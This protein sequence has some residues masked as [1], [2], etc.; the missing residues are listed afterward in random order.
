MEKS[1]IKDVT[2]I[3]V[4]CVNYSLTIKS[5]RNCMDKCEF[6]RVVF[7]TDIDIKEEGIEVIKIDRINSKEEYSNFIIKYLYKY[8]ETS[9]CLIVQHDGTILNSKCWN[10]DFKDYDYIGAKWTYTDGRNVG[11]GGFSLRSWDLQ[12]ILGNDKNIIITSPEDECI[13]RLYRNYL[14]NEYQVK[15]APEEI[16]DKFSFELHAPTQKTFGHHNYFF[17]EFKEHIILKRTA[18][19]G[20]VL[21]L[22]P[23]I[24]YYCNKNYQVV[25]DTLPEFM[26][27]FSSYKYLIKH[28]SQMD[29]RIVPIKKIN[30]DMAYE[31]NPTQL[32]LKSYIELT[33]EKIPLSNSNLM[34]HVEQSAKLFQKLILIHI[35]ETGMPYRN[36]QGIDWKF[37][38]S[39]YT[40]LGFLV[41]QIGKRMNNQVAH[42]INTQNI[43]TLLFMI[44]GAN[45]IIGIDS[46]P[47]QMAVALGV[48]CVIFS[49]SVDLRLRY[50]S[51]DSIE[52]IHTDCPSGKDRYCYHETDGSTTG[53]PCEFNEIKPPCVQYSEYS[54][55]KS[56]NKLLNL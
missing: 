5:L 24:R 46:S 10:E 44:S 21:M 7:L 39:Y 29:S 8:F 31:N 12:N 9:H 2:L 55:I 22:E 15:F 49:G 30:L 25:L 52:V 54:I 28:I 23:V 19:M 51:F 20:D 18:A 33:G 43:E 35:D 11:N 6:D 1:K 38:V 53:K 42:Y 41:M 47:C 36:A 56:A 13:G 48:P 50:Y 17:N 27:L 16:C 45:L 40:K 32:V 34:F 3:A 26:G 14:E 4:D 37:V